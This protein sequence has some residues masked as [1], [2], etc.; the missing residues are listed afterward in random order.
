MRRLLWLSSA[1]VLSCSSQP[2]TDTETEDLHNHPHARA[3]IH[4]HDA[5]AK[6]LQTSE[7]VWAFT[8]TGS[9]NTSNHTVTWQISAVRGST[10]TG[11]LIVDGFMD[12][13]ND[14]LGG[15]TIGNIVV[16]LQSKHHDHHGHKSTDWKTLSSD[17]A[18]ATQNDAATTAYVDA[19]AVSEHVGKFT[20]NAASGHLV[21]MD[22]TNN[23]VFSLVPEKTVPA[24]TSVP[25][26]FS[27]TFDNTDLDL[28]VGDDVRVEVIVTFGN[29]G[30]NGDSAANVDINGNGVIDPDEDH[31]RSVATHHDMK[32]PSATHV[33]QTP[34]ITDDPSDLA[35]TGTV[36]VSNPT[37]N[38]G[39]TSGTVTLHYDAGASGGSVTNC[40][41][42]DSPNTVAQV[43][44]YTYNDLDGIHL[45]ACNTETIHAPT[46]TPGASG[47]GWRDG[48]LVTYTQAS[49]GGDPA[50]DAG[51]T[52]LVA[53]FDTVYAATFG[54]TVGSFSGF[55]MSFT[56][57]PSVLAYQPSIGPFGPLNGNVL[58]PISTASGGFGGEVLGL[59]FN[60]DFSDAGLLHGTSGLRVGDLTL[61]GMSGGQAVLNGQTIRQFLAI[62][63]SLLGDTATVM[64]I[65]DLNTLVGDVNGA[66]FNGTPSTFAQAHVVNGSCP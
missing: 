36:S 60:V 19:H 56:D 65:T 52:L 53:D 58:N 64:T 37:F 12:V 7:T 42:L 20:E 17:V 4:L 46:C 9:V 59:E 3:D 49:W 16:N 55:T 22:A 63:N 38:L 61:C 28:D 54:V 31:V 41:H 6:L 44:G 14:G 62:V 45:V 10:D 23:T 48:D 32:V 50:I 43:G 29:S 57:A 26:L 24:W 13:T 51:A 47:C 18:D 21:F 2:A 15:A 11:N 30:N 33:N 25:L 39:A 35:T 66:F 27:A 5:D 1:L 8:K 34:T 40:A